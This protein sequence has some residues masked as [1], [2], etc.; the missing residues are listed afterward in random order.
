MKEAISISL[1]EELI[2]ELDS[3]RGLVPRSAYIEFLLKKALFGGFHN[4][5]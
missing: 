1:S 3:K 2:K 5:G 4:E